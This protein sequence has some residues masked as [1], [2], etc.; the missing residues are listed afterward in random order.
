[1]VTAETVLRENI[2]RTDA[3]KKG[4][5]RRLLRWFIENGGSIH[6][7][8][9]FRLD[10]AG[11][12]SAYAK[13]DIPEPPPG[14]IQLCVCPPKLQLSY[15]RIP[16]ELREILP[17]HVCANLALIQEWNLRDSSLW[18]PYIHCLPR[19]EQMTTP[20]YFDDR[21]GGDTVWLRGTNLNAAW[22]ERE[23]QWANEYTRCR[24]ALDHVGLDFG[25]FSLEIYKWAATI[26]TSR[27]FPSDPG[28]SERYRVLLPVVDLL[29]HKFPTKVN[30]FFDR[31]SFSLKSEEPLVQSQPVFN[32]YGG[33]GNEE[34][35]NGYGFC[36]QDNPCDVVAI[37]F[38]QLPPPVVQ[39]LEE[40]LGEWDPSQIHYVRGRDFYG[41]LYPV[42]LEDF[43]KITESGIP[44]ALWTVLE[45][46]KRHQHSQRAS[47]RNT[48][49]A[50]CDLLEVLA[51]KYDNIDQHVVSLPPT[52]ANDKQRYAKMYRDGQMKILKE[53]VDLL[54]GAL[55]EKK[56]V[57]LDEALATLRKDN[58]AAFL[59]WERMAKAVF[60]T[61]SL[62]KIREQD[63]EAQAWMM[64]F[65]ESWVFLSDNAHGPKWSRTRHWINNLHESHPLR[66]FLTN[67]RYDPIF[68]KV[69]E[70]DIAWRKAG[71]YT[72][73][74]HVVNA[75]SRMLALLDE[76]EIAGKLLICMEGP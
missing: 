70:V 17:E 18:A 45:V 37:R 65:C 33:K 71:L 14:G 53:N 23:V 48:L 22:R 76:H 30:W 15:H 50:R 39:E 16:P 62:D 54:E 9:L 74:T 32:N 46:I 29:N 75:E 24:T 58:R 20:M 72:W 13:E 1:M 40:I 28:A 21:N 25:R 64:W 44:P 57:T 52:P 49:S 8:V 61:Q 38:G 27:C 59:R 4:D 67:T 66:D 73:A 6:P 19:P 26:F 42:Q 10:D 5:I 2:C 31:G 36:I 7:S 35:L 51:T 60:D 12:I 63:M 3:S 34:L 68:R 43:P 11:G 69:D 56:W 41:G 47:W 55:L